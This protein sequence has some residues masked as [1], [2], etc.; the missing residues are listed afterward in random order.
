MLYKPRS[1]IDQNTLSHLTQI[2][3]DGDYLPGLFGYAVNSDRYP[4]GFGKRY[5]AIRGEKF[6]GEH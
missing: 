3:S 4:R 1:G 6:L 2:Y 5:M